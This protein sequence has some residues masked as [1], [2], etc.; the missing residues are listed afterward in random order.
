AGTGY[1]NILLTPARVLRIGLGQT[2]LFRAGGRLKGSDR[3][4][5]VVAEI[6]TFKA[7]WRRPYIGALFAGMPR[8]TETA[9]AL[10][11]V[12]MTGAGISALV[13]RVI[14]NPARADEVAE[15]LLDRKDDL[16]GNYGGVLYRKSVVPPGGP[17]APPWAANPLAALNPVEGGRHRSPMD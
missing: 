10:P 17:D 9:S 6:D 12:G 2:L 7:P 3:F 5:L 4:S 16:A 15:I 8:L 11:V 14:S 1:T 13:H